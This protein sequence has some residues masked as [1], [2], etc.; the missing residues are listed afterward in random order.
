MICCV[1][2]GLASW[3]CSGCPLPDPPSAR[4]A[5]NLGGQSTLGLL[6]PIVLLQKPL[7]ALVPLVVG[8]PHPPACPP[9][10]L[11][12]LYLCCLEE[13]EARTGKPRFP[14]GCPAFSEGCRHWHLCSRGL[15]GSSGACDE[16]LDEGSET[17]PTCWKE[18]LLRASG[19]R[20]TAL[21][22]YVEALGCSVKKRCLDWNSCP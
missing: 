7:V 13:W 2:A 5:E 9:C 14:V 22:S 16:L 18:L 12:V 10:R 21:P 11:P 19:C 15:A 1:A 20:L 8:Q 6:S 3:K 17:H 4:K